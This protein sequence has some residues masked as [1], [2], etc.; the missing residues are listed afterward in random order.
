MALCRESAGDEGPQG[1]SEPAEGRRSRIGEQWASPGMTG[2]RKPV[3][4]GDVTQFAGGSAIS[5]MCCQRQVLTA[6]LAMGMLRIPIC[7][8]TLMSSLGPAWPRW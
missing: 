3:L 6:L 7:R 8:G 2:G 1:G 5:L 4:D